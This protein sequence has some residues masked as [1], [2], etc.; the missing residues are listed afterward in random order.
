MGVFSACQDESNDNQPLT[1]EQAR[2]AVSTVATQMNDDFTELR[3]SQG[4][5]ALMEFNQI[6][7]FLNEPAGKLNTRRGVKQLAR[8]IKSASQSAST[9]RL[10][11]VPQD[12]FDFEE[13]KGV[14]EWDE[15]I[16]DFVMTDE[17]VDYIEFRFPTGESTTNNGSLKILSFEENEDYELIDLSAELAI[18]G[19][20]LLS[21]RLVTESTASSE[22]VSLDMF[23]S[24]FELSLSTSE[25]T[26]G[27]QIDFSMSRDEIDLMMVSLS[28][29]VDEQSGELE[30]I[31]GTISY[32]E[33][34]IEG[35]LDFSNIANITSADQM[36][37]LV[38]L[39][40]SYE[41]NKVGDV[42]FQLDNGEPVPYIEY[43]DGSR[44]NLET[45][46][47]PIFDQLDDLELEIGLI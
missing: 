47:Q 8:V 33:L 10:K 30:K 36:N 35:S 37:E 23:V 40:V 2:E 14:Y 16:Q 24:P 5:M 21:I 34:T 18:D 39:S 12:E 11:D 20:L 19:E 46:I 41:G 15:S 42:V 3:E 7:G 27:A 26:S 13:M 4:M 6:T 38:N 1:S 28:I 29:S 32:R 9:A 17:S 44:E 25:S 43:A 22:S 31:A 45:L